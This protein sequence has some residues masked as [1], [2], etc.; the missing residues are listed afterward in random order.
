M[1]IDE[2]HSLADPVDIR[3]AEG[4]PPPENR[5]RTVW[6][7]VRH[8]F[9]LAKQ[10]FA[11]DPLVGGILFAIKLGIGAGISYATVNVQLTMASVT[12]ALAARNGAVIPG[13]LITAIATFAGVIVA[14]LLGDWVRYTLRIRARSVLTGSLLGR[15]LDGNRYYDLERRARLDHP[16]QRIQ[17]DV[18]IYVEEMLAIVPGLIGSLL[19]LFLYSGKLWTMSPP[20]P[21]NGIG[22]PFT[23]EGYLVYS[24]VGFALLWTV[25]THLVGAKLTTTEI[26]RQGLEAQFRQEMAGVRE[27]SEAIAFQKGA[28][29]EG[30]RLDSTFQLIKENWRRYTYANLRVTFATQIPTLLFL[31]GPAALCAP[32]VISGRMQVGDI[33][34]VAA[35]MI[36]VFSAVGVVIQSYRQLA[37]LRSAVSRLR[38]FDE[39][40][41]GAARPDGIAVVA[42]ADN[43]YSTR[44]LVIDRPTGEPMVEVED[45][46]IRKGAR[47]L[48][49]GQSGAGKSTFLRA[50][51][52]LWCHG[53]GTVAAPADM[54]VHFVPQ[55]S[56]MPDGTLASLMA[57]P[58][59]PGSVS[60]E[61]FRM[62]LDRLGLGQLSPRLHDYASWRRIL[63]P[64]EQQ[65]IAAARAILAAPDFLFVDEATSALDMHS[66]AIF[67]TLLAERLPDAAI[68]SV[69]HRPTVEAYHDRA[70]E[71]AQG[72]A[73][74]FAIDRPGSPGDTQRN[75]S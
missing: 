36:A 49:K 22:L 44:N 68:I 70:I 16:E 27:N 41:E 8:A 25:V 23:L 9:G 57:Y 48:V 63:S 32:F 33:Q 59:D 55:R 58:A 47:I 46:V 6:P 18:F 53:S 45:I 69:A 51:A 19:P 54:R 29:F 10:Y 56:Y 26:T 4:E 12:T 65:R 3:L 72:K 30:A 20:V 35:A 38:Y 61:T 1:T 50:L 42:S 5:G 31:M 39:L 62:L 13:L 34:F 2:S 73:R 66:E 15:W 60:D 40:L 71:F 43:A 52:G 28:V 37:I 24:T 67:Y 75:D 14:A 7:D 64:G 11:K 21:L 74:Q 17:E